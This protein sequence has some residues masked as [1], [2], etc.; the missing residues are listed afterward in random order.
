M[1]R[2]FLAALA[3][4]CLGLSLSVAQNINK[5]IQL[6][7]DSSGSFGVDS[8]NNVYFPAHILNNGPGNPTAASCGTTPV[9]S[10]DST[11][12][13]GQ[14]TG[15]SANQAGCLLSFKTAYLQAPKCVVTAQN[16]AT[17]PLAYNVVATGINITGTNMGA[18]IANYVCF[19]AK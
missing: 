15:G 8:N 11:D 10:T 17:S 7:Q 1:K 18:A 14:V 16:P 13:F 9:V 19:G 5:A 3:V 12:N 2:F 6:S 4:V